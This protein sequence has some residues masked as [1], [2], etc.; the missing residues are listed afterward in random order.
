MTERFL[1]ILGREAQP[2]RQ[3]VGLF[4]PNLQ[5]YPGGSSPALLAVNDPGKLLTLPGNA[6]FLL[7]TVFH[8]HG[9]S[10]PV[11]QFAPN[12]V[13]AIAATRGQHLIDRFWGRYV[14]VIRGRDEWLVLRDPS[15]ILPCYYTVS[16]DELV[17]ASD[18]AILVDAAGSVPQ[19]DIPQ[20]ARAL[21]LG[22]FPEERTALAGVS[23]ILPGMA[24]Q[25]RRDGISTSTRWSP[26]KFACDQT[27]RTVDDHAETLRRITQLSVSGYT[28][29]DGRALLGV[30]GGLDSSIVAACLQATRSDFAC[31][32]LKT[33]DPLG[34]E[35]PFARALTTHLGRRLLEERYVLEDVD[36]DRSSV[37]HLPKPFGRLETQAY[38]AAVVR[39]AKQIN[40][41]A[42]FTGNGGDNVFYMSHSAR[43]LADRFSANG[44]SLAL[45]S[46][47]P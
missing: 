42:I 8:R 13:E 33:D 7:G 4:P 47:C 27:G 45:M 43:P 29:V 19:L 28:A 21:A 38:D 10:K 20:L 41:S 26:W 6:G 35:R 31:I 2:V 23:Q 22:G 18:P 12:D 39:A 16:R 15:G 11:H 32:T 37:C 9:P 34:D 5:W 1:C 25:V 3:I 46:L 24:L 40:A 44:W 14:A 17:L 36:L 30:S